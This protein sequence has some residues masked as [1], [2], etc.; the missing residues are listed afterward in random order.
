M[1]R[2]VPN[3]PESLLLHGPRLRALAR[4]LVGDESSADDLVQETWVRALEHGPGHMTSLWRWLST[5]LRNLA[6]DD[7]RLEAHRAQRERAVARGEAASEHEERFA[8]HKELVAAI[9]W[10]PEPYRQAILL[11]YFEDLP[12]RRIATRLGVPVKTVKKRLNRGI[13]LLRE[14]LDR[15]HGGREEWL[16]SLLPLLRRPSAWPF[17]A[18]TLFQVLS[19][20]SAIAITSAAVLVVAGIYLILPRRGSP[21]VVPD[22]APVVAA[23]STLQSGP[24]LQPAEGQPVREA[25]LSSGLATQPAPELVPAPTPGRM[26]GRVLD[27][28][29]NELAGVR[30]GFDVKSDPQPVVSGPH[31][32]F[33]LAALNRTVVSLDERFAT[34]LASRLDP[35]RSRPADIL[36]VVVAPVVTLGGIVLDEQGAPVAGATVQTEIPLSFRGRFRETLESSVERWWCDCGRSSWANKTDEQGRFLLAQVPGLTCAK[37]VARASHDRTA[38]VPVPDH[39]ERGLE[40]VLGAAHTH[41]YT[42]G[43]DSVHL[44]GEVRHADGGL[45]PGALVSLDG[46]SARAD[47]QALFELFA[48]PSTRESSDV[49]LAAERQLLAALPGEQAAVFAPT[50]DASGDELWPSFV[51]LRLGGAPKS[52]TGHVFGSDG[53][54][55]AKAAVWIEDLTFVGKTERTQEGRQSFLTLESQMAGNTDPLAEHPWSRVYSDE[56]GRFELTGLRDR[57]YTI[58]AMHPETLQVTQAG[59]IAAG[60]RDVELMMAADELWERVAGRVVDSRGNPF[61]GLRVTPKRSTSHIQW[62][63]SS[64]REFAAGTGVLTDD[65]GGFEL[66]RIPRSGILLEIRGDRFV[67]IELELS[68][69]ADPL[70]VLVEVPWLGHVQIELVDPAAEGGSIELLGPDERL[71]NFTIF[72]GG[73]TWTRDAIQL[74]NENEFADGRTPVLSVPE[75]ARAVV[76]RDAQGNELRRVPLVLGEELTTV[77]L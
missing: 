49:R 61:V 64:W 46:V 3:H 74:G 25:V 27:Q 33:E 31:G 58:A 77:R 47:E 4:K 75:T 54:P 71:V 23:E 8:G 51:T 42:P 68:Q 44:L 41:G 7:R 26:R 1:V 5:V 72:G 6:S 67:P 30:V 63:K 36:T 17:P 43:P 24:E 62:E 73:S 70:N 34:V 9:D 45:A 40:L 13:A 52:I 65:T 50:Y 76:L 66:E 53:Q 48:P 16:A 15:K 2:D 59:P 57:P 12:P 18:P 35:V 22:S 37:L 56:N 21:S 20:K 55:I 39:D 29:G 11:R 19:M 69:V 60:T 28:N 14:E 32:E 38:R 10:L